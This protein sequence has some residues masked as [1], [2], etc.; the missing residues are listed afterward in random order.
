MLF[1]K[2][3]ESLTARSFS[4]SC[5]GFVLIINMREALIELKLKLQILKLLQR[6]FRYQTKINI[7][8]KVTHSLAQQ[9]GVPFSPQRHLLT[10]GVRRAPQ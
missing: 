1:I 8:F 9:K 6:S 10:L 4:L 7:H 2:Y 3:N 5:L